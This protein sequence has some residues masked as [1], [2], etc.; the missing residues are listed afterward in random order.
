MVEGH[1]DGKSMAKP[2]RLFCDD[3]WLVKLKRT[4][5][6]LHPEKKGSLKVED[7]NGELKEVAIEDVRD[8]RTAL[9]DLDSET[10]LRWTRD[11]KRP[12]YWSDDLYV[13]ILNDLYNGIAYRIAPRQ[14]G[15]SQRL[16]IRPFRARARARRVLVPSKP[17][18]KLI[19][20]DPEHSR[21]I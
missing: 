19:I 8:Y 11:N 3:A 2:P 20:W 17:P 10:G 5:T 9:W 21:H 7:K 1:L 4:D 18:L 15:L 16:R 6:A 12:Y 14:L 13:Y